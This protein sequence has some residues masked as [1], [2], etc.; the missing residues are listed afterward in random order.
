MNA[1]TQNITEEMRQ[2]RQ[3]RDVFTL[4]NFLAGSRSI[5]AFS[6]QISQETTFT[7]IRFLTSISCLWIWEG[8]GGG[9]GT[10]GT[11]ANRRLTWC[12]GRVATREGAGAQLR[13]ALLDMQ[14]WSTGRLFSSCPLQTDYNRPLKPYNDLM[15]ARDRTL[16]GCLPY[17]QLHV[18]LA[19]YT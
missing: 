8:R 18:T 10:K 19:T 5:K 6:L 1:E 16:H 17:A 7:T 15:F 13:A 4:R 12:L 14:A 9:Q 3:N 11:Q 2:C